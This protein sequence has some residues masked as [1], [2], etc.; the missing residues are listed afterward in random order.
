MSV[1]FC[2]NCGLKR[3]ERAN[4]CSSCQFNFKS[5]NI[6]FNKN[7]S[8]KETIVSA[9]GPSNILFSIISYI[10]NGI[11][12]FWFIWLYAIA[13]EMIKRGEFPEF[14]VMVS[15]IVLTILFYVPSAFLY[16]RRGGFAFWGA[17]I[18]SMIMLVPE[19]IFLIEFKEFYNAVGDMYGDID[20][21]LFIPI[22]PIFFSLIICAFNVVIV[23]FRL[24]RKDKQRRTNIKSKVS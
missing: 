23:C 8:K 21:F 14:G 2:P 9:K 16:Y 4:F 12:V 17:A 24:M 22:I 13:K 1:N 5:L 11:Y 10:A 19:F 6:N 20:Q 7:V 15:P 3:E 18:I